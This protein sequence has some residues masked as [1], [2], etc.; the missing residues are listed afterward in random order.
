MGL[1]IKIFETNDKKY[2]FDGLS[3]DLYEIEDE[4]SLEE[5][6]ANY[7][8]E[9]MDKDENP[10]NR[11]LRKV[12]INTSNECNLHC[13]YCYAEGGSYGRQCSKMEIQ[14]FDRIINDLKLQG[15]TEIGVFSFFGGEPLMNF[16]LIKYGIPKI[17]ED[18][19]V[20]NF[21]VVTNGT[22]LTEEIIY[23]FKKYDVSLSISLDG[24]EKIN[25]FLRGAGVYK[26][27]K[28]S[29]ELCKKLNYSRL[30]ISATYTKIHEDAGISYSD[31]CHLLAEEQV[32]MTVS[33][34]LTKDEELRLCKK[35]DKETL[36]QDIHYSL[37]NILKK[38]HSSNVNPYVNAFLLSLA[39]QAKTKTFCDDLLSKYS[40]TYDYNG[41]KYNCFRFWNDATYSIKNGIDDERIMKA[42]DKN[43]YYQCADCWAKNMCKICIAAVLQGDDALPFN[44][45]RCANREAFEIV[46]HEVAAIVA[47][48]QQTNLVRNYKDSFVFYK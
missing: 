7:K 36:K 10:N 41:E 29:L 31:L 25:D 1:P 9:N 21:E 42:N 37:D 40:I 16:P 5:Y 13:K 12:V 43:Q 45:E 17:L 22:R 35:L 47:Q 24:P 46:L 26:R 34:V 8:A 11:A 14:T 6:L 23:F 27:A 2:L 20:K 33:S 19:T 15:I 4:E 39:F 18:F 28:K 44:E 30:Y 38:E 48:G 3:F 32:G